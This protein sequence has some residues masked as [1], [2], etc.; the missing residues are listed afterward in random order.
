MDRNNDD[1]NLD[2]FLRK[3]SFEVPEASPLL[4]ER[5]W[6][7]LRQEEKKISKSAKS[8]W[9][10][11]LVTPMALGLLAIVSTF[12]LNKKM[13]VV[14]SDYANQQEVAQFI[15]DSFQSDEDFDLDG[16]DL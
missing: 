1:S 13:N 10:L 9:F 8:F 6:A 2:E 15:E 14:Q 7:Q 5:L 3:N 4:K 12:V 16:L 11:R